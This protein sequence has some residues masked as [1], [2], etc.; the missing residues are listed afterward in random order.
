M[1]KMGKKRMMDRIER[2][3]KR[4]DGLIAALFELA[5]D[6]SDAEGFGH[7]AGLDELKHAIHNAA[8]VLHQ[9]LVA[10]HDKHGAIEGGTG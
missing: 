4:V 7:Q 10:L 8:S 3:E 9:D 6:L 1:R 2:L 5:E